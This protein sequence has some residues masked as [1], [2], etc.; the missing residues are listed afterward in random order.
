MTVLEEKIDDLMA[1]MTLEEKVALCHAGS[2]FAVGEIKRIGIPEFWMSDGPHGVRREIRRDLWDP[3]E[4]ETDYATYLPTGTALASTW[5]LEL[6]RRFGEVLGAEARERRKDVILGPG[7]NIVRTP[8]CGRNFE[9]YSED[10]HQVASMV[11]PAIQGIQSQDVAA[12]VKHY[13]A[14]SQELNRTGVDAQMDERTL[15]E[16]YLPGFEAAVT[17]GGVLTVMGAYNKFR[18]QFCCHHEYLVNDILKGEWAFDGCFISDWNGA[19]DTL[20]AAKY[21]LDIEMGTGCA[22]YEE[23]F[24]ARPFRDALERGELDST[25]LDDKVRRVLRVM[26]R[27]GIFREDRKPGERNTVK[28]QQAALEIAREAIIL[29]KNENAVLPFKQS[30]LRRL[31]VIGD[32]ATVKHALGGNSAAVKTSYEVTPLEGL[33]AK[34]GTEVEIQY[35]RGYPTQDNAS[36]PIKAEYLGTGDEGAGTHGWKGYYYVHREGAWSNAGDPVRRAD[37]EIDF[38]WTDSAPFPEM[39]PEQYS[40]RWETTLTPPQRGTYEFILTGASHAEISIDGFKLIQFWEN[41]GPEVITKSIELESGRVYSLVI[42]LKPNHR[43]V[44]VKLGWIPPWVE[45][46]QQNP[47]E[48]IQ[49]VK[50]ADAVVFFGGQNHQYDIE[51]SDRVDMALH[52]GQNE[53]LAQI[54]GLNP[55]TAVVLVSGSPVEMPWINEARAIVQ[56]WYAG[57]EGGNAIAEIL[58]GEVNPSGKLSMTFP[59]HLQDSP[60]HFLGDYAADVCRYEEG[61]FVGYRWFNA[62][63][64]KPLFPF[65]HGLS[66]TTFALANM[67]LTEESDGIRVCLELMN[68]GGQ[69]GAEVVQIYVGQPECS[70]VRPVRELKGFAKVR[71]SPRETERM[72]F[73]LE[74]DA[75]AYWSLENNAWTIEPGEFVIEAGFSSQDLP[76]KQTIKIA[77][78]SKNQRKSPSFSLFKNS[79]CL[80]IPS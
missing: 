41:G 15:R 22:T 76:C 46:R 44:R 53:L 66:Y 55:N 23:Y 19:H 33:Q 20:E 77:G 37:S 7:I 35:F 62:K 32:N 36:E 9:Y 42:R 18:G 11:V 50:D 12:C 30:Q 80:N 38:D 48:L 51:G 49:A 70:V 54:L 59:K 56:M 58:L 52:D 1:Q 21:G 16:I 63:G 31:V 27:I 43:E 61:I 47:K 26:S 67:Q 73:F 40:V 3:V 6:A 68:T 57:M 69:T 64:I 71:L 28:H 39:K 65:G 29:L 75:F 14:N 78:F 25:L 8:L 74:A 4:T 60:A 10:P 5:N 45:T 2:K 72:E 34:L 13:A 79:S 17:K 24:L